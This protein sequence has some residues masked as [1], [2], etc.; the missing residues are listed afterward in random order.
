[1]TDSIEQVIKHIADNDLSIL[2]ESVDI[3]CKL[4]SGQD[5]KGELPADFWQSYSAFANTEGGVVVLGVKEKNGDFTINGIQQVAKIKKQLFD[6]AD[7]TKKVSCNLITDRSVVE[8]CI[9]GKTILLIGIPK[10]SRKQQPVYLNGNPMGNSYI[11]RHEG[12]YRL[13]DNQ[14]KQLLAEQT[15][16][17][18]DEILSDYGLEDIAITS[19]RAYR[20][21]YANLNPYA[22]LNEL[23]D[24]EFLR[25]I[26]AYGKNRQ[27][28]EQ[29]L[30]K[31]GLLMFGQHH[32]ICEIFPHYL[33]DYQEKS[34][35]ESVRWTD[36]VVSGADWSSNLYEFYHRVISKLTQSLKTPF[37]LQDGVRQEDTP[38]HIAIREALAN[39][40]I[41]ADYTDRASIRIIKKSHGFEFRNP[42]LM[43]IPIEVA[44][45]GAETDCRNPKIQQMFRLIHISEQAGSGI[46][47]I[48]TGWQSQ[49]WTPPKLKQEREPYH[50]TLLELQM[51]D[52]FPEKIMDKLKNA[53]GK[54]FVALSYEEQIILAIAKMQ[55]EVSHGMLKDILDKHPVDITKMLQQLVLNHFLIKH[56][57]GRWATYVLNSGH[58]EPS[59]GHN[60]PSI[61]HND[62]HIIDD[63][64]DLT[65]DMYQILDEIA[66][67]SQLKDRLKPDEM[68][69]IIISLC[70]NGFFTTKALAKLLNRGEESLRKHYL[71]A[72]VKQ[73][74]LILAYPEAKQHNKQAYR[75]NPNQ[76]N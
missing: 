3:E 7:N 68:K 64:D 65:D 52:L 5:G 15:D 13:D 47:K 44:R 70:T 19:L 46:P 41:H 51:I 29:G 14:V 2:Q 23:E 36:R 12:D 49:H 58:N 54:P 33:L 45:H 17:R 37:V 4:A 43:R 34:E 48:F 38:V 1:M 20:Q 75:T 72:L 66:K 18:D 56:G 42:G 30:T 6:L 62:E 76:P 50:Q 9:E 27:T 40:I 71:S 11:R 10:A 35:D 63:L 61:G 25:R 60:E 21:R 24:L 59:I 8:W 22:E 31:A 73:D 32:S 55:N 26:G 57:Y 53:Y 39:A 67:P 69:A 74:I 28:G 16:S